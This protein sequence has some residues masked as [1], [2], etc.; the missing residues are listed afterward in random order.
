MKQ[1]TLLQMLQTLLQML[2][3]ECGECQRNKANNSDGMDGRLERHKL[4][5]HPDDLGN[6]HSS[7][8]LKEIEFVT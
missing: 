5:S 1:K 6:L 7:K 2:L 8:F 3:R 4:K